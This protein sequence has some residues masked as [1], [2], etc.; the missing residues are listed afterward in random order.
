M[1]KVE[2][3]VIIR[4]GEDSGGL[5]LFVAVRLNSSSS[6][7]RVWRLTEVLVKQLKN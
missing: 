2:K 6:A 7:A 1:N 5:S 3:G 4:G